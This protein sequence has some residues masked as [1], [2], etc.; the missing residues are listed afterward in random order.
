MTTTV[1]DVLLAA[2]PPL[3]VLVLMV[4]FRWGGS[5]AGPAGWFVA[6]V[7]AAL[8]F[9]AGLDVL[10]YAHVRALVLTVD[11]VYIIWAALLLYHV[12]DQAGA[13]RVI[14]AWFTHLTGDDVLRVLLLG[15]VFTSFLQGVGGF[16][17]PVAIVAPLLVGLGL[18]P[19]AAVLIPS[20][21]H[22]WAVTFG[23]LASSFI[24]L[25]GVTGLDPDLLAP[26]AALL[27][28]VMAFGSGL[29][30]AH[31]FAGWRGLRRALPAVL[32]IGFVMAIVQYV[33][34]TNGLWNVGASGASLAGLA[35][36][37]WVTR[38][39]FYR[40]GGASV[41]VPAE[42]APTPAAVAPDA[43]A[44]RPALSFPLAIAGYVVLVVLA[45]A[46]KGIAPIRTLFT[47]FTFAIAVP[48]VST[49]LGWVTPATPDL[50][51]NLLSHTGAVLVYSS[52]IAYVLYRRR[53]CYGPGAE[54]VILS[55]VLKKGVRP[56]L[57]IMAM[58]GMATVMSNAGMTR[59]LAEWLAGAVPLDL[60][61]FVATAI[62]TL[63]S[64]MTGS[65]TNSN[66][67]FASLQQETAVLL[68]LNVLLVLGVQ[69]ASAAIASVFAPA[70]IIVGASTVGAGG[71][72]GL[73]LRRLLVYG[74]VLLLVLALL[75]FV[76]L[77]V[78]GAAAPAM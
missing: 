1:L 77:R 6:L 56:A 10:G 39:P 37:M 67:V 72:E 5:K 47:P 55:G 54:R 66:A 8:R 51:L 2:A 70:K 11:V 40:R 12:V 21:G 15:W 20:L 25:V 63:G 3:T 41:V 50:G 58:V 7:I 27:L 59:A 64:F 23:S 53:G 34:A 44:A 14:A 69:T 38:W 49:S 52:V 17:V 73:I 19:L 31:A 46:I 13:M 18:T 42:D 74:G 28:G 26:P 36:G 4:G 65:N 30:A 43:D 9:G 76:L 78:D 57:G 60:Y 35:V 68:G 24:A 45:V 71:D 32:A 22:G 16:G 62:G 75:A 29:L 48:E 33:L 61:A